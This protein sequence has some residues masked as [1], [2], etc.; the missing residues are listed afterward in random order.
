MYDIP[1]E[2]V[3]DVWSAVEP[4]LSKAMKHHP[5]LDSPGLL[6]LLVANF[7]QLMIATEDGRILGAIVMERT[8]YPDRVVGNVV[9]FGGEYGVYR[10]YVNDIAAHCEAWSRKHGCDTIGFVGRPGWTRFALRHGGKQVRLVHAWKSLDP[11]Q[12]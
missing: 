9:A 8:A 2:M 7:A 11:L 3:T 12:G 1:R 4:M 10:K 5:H 6:K